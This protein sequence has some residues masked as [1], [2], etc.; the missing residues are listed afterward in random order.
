MDTLVTLFRNLGPTRLA[1]MAFVIVLMAGFFFTV[2]TRLNAPTMA[3][4]YGSL[5]PQQAS[6]IVDRLAAENIPYEIRGESSIYVPDTQVGQLRLKIAGSGLVGASSAGYE[7]FDKSSGFGTTSLVQNINARRVMEGELA[8]T[9]QSLPAV[10]AARVHLVLPTR[11]LF[12]R[13]ETQPSASVWV[14]LSDRVL[15]A[16]QIQSI[17][18]LVA[19]A[20][21]N[22]TPDKVTVV[23]NRGN[24]L[25]K[26]EGK[27]SSAATL[28]ASTAYR[29]KVETDYALQLTRMLERVV[30]EGKVNVQVTADVN[31]DRVEENAEIFDPEGQVVR[32]EQRSENALNS[33]ATDSNPPVGLSSNVPGQNPQGSSV[34]N[35]ENENRVDETINYEI[36]KTI[37]RQVREG[38]NVRR[39]SVA[40]LVE[41]KTEG[42]GAEA[43]YVPLSAEETEKMRTLVRSAIGFDANRGDTVEIIDMPF[44]PVVEPAPEKEPL[45]TKAEIMQMVE[46]GLMLLGLLM[47]FLFVIRPISKALRQGAQ[48]TAANQEAAA[49]GVVNTAADE[50]ETMIDIAKVE[51]RVRESTIRKV[52]EIVE[53]HPDE[54]VN[55]I[56]QWMTPEAPSQAN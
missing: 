12:S 33:Q 53:K 32:S 17:T 40:V 13:E 46:Y 44:S 50:S 51:G 36:S 15:S 41:G 37:R 54:S 56:R 1:T 55:V 31:F 49:L 28:D 10:R 18:H 42:T 39:L 22:L 27:D 8:R 43:K 2:M 3:L 52:A 26:G 9:I 14:N 34:T 21:P 11:Q 35:R 45:L 6:Q 16:E 24:L 30:G 38:G 25:S 29:K 23:D 19:A 20:V 47:M 5:E 4:L 7:I 48:Q